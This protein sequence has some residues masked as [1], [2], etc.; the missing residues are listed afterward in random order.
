M[1]GFSQNLISYA[2]SAGMGAKKLRN[3]SL[4][5]FTAKALSDSQATLTPFSPT[6]SRT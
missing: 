4:S 1:N 5:R 6:R 3:L 2:K